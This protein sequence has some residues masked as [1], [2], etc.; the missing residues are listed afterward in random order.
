MIYAKCIRESQIA[1]SHEEFMNRQNEDNPVYCVG[2]TTLAK[3]HSNDLYC[4]PLNFIFCCLK[5]GDYIAIVDVPNDVELYPKP[6]YY[7]N[8]QIAMR[9]QKILAIFKAESKEAI[10]YVAE[11]VR[12]HDCMALNGYINGFSVECKDYYNKRLVNDPENYYR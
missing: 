12:D 9:E 1:H 5:H 6:G 3:E 10:D 4:V 8:Y 11:H 2:E 7:N